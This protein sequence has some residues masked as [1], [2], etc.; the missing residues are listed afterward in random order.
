LS[1]KSAKK[2]YTTCLVENTNTL[3]NQNKGVSDRFTGMLPSHVVETNQGGS[4][5]KLA[6]VDRQP[7]RSHCKGS[8]QFLIGPDVGRQTN[9][10]RRLLIQLADVFARKKEILLIV[11]PS[12]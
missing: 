11:P 7:M 9:F 12:I 8:Q 4:E 2:L 6:I 1:E 3:K 10:A 5:T